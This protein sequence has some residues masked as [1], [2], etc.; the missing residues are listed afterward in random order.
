[1]IL[2]SIKN[3]KIRVKLLLLLFLPASLLIYLSYS[4][5]S[6]EQLIIDESEKLIQ[7]IELSQSLS[8]I[9]HEIQLERGYTGESFFGSD[10]G[11]E[12]L[13]ALYINT[14]ERINQFLQKINNSSLFSYTEFQDEIELNELIVSLDRI[15]SVRHRV[16]NEQD[17]AY[18]PYFE[19]YTKLI[20]E[21]IIF[22]KYLQVISSDSVILHKITTYLNLLQAQEYAGQERAILNTIF[23]KGEINVELYRQIVE[24]ISQQN[25]FLDSFYQDGF[26]SFSNDLVSR[27]NTS[28]TKEMLL[29]RQAG[30]DKAKKNSVLNQLQN[31]IGYGGLIHDFKNFVMRGNT[32][33]RM[34]FNQDIEKVKILINEYS[35]LAGM[36][37]KERQFLKVIQTTLEK[38][39]SMLMVV[40][41][42]KKQGASI[43][44]IDHIVNIND[45]PAKTA[46]G[47][48]STYVTGLESGNWFSVSTQR[49]ENMRQ[50][51][52]KLEDDI[53]NTVISKYKAESSS[54]LLHLILIV[55]VLAIL[56][57]LSFML[58]RRMVVEV[59]AMTKKIKSM[60][61]SGQF[62]QLLEV[63]GDDEIAL[64]AD[65]FDSLILK[66]REYQKKMWQQAY[67]DDL[68]GLANRKRCTE[69]IVEE[70][71]RS[72]RSHTPFSVLFI[73][74]D[75]FKIINDSLGHQIGDDLLCQA[76]KRLELTI[77]N[78]DLL[79][80][81]GGD[82]FVIVLT[83][84]HNIQ[85][86]KV[87]ANSL[88]NAL[89]QNFVLDGVHQTI[90]SGSIGIAMYPDDGESV[91]ILLKNADT[92][93]YQ[94]K[95]KGK[96][97]YQFFTQ[98]MNFRV[99]NYMKIEQDMHTALEYQQFELFY[100]PVIDLKSKKIVS[101]EAL[102]RWNSPQNGLVF[103]DDFVPI[104]EETGMIVPL[105]KWIM[106]QAMWQIKD[107]NSR[108]DNKIKMAINV[109][110]RQFCDRNMPIYK[111]LNDLLNVVG[112]SADLIE[113]EITENLLMENSSELEKTLQQISEKGFAIFM[114]D[115]GT[116]YSSLSYL[117]KFPIDVLKIDRSFVWNMDKD[118]GDKRLV[119]S[120]INMAKSMELTV[121][122]E[123]VE[124][125]KHEKLLA[126]MGCDLAQ[127][128]LYSK[129]VPAKELEEKFLLQSD[130]ANKGKVIPL[131]IKTKRIQ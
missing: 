99:M 20:H 32:E 59:S 60:R 112:I 126:E 71:E 128:Y 113:L 22:I 17:G 23:L 36:S 15:K 115:F 108:C 70:I 129:P 45:R 131:P 11:T 31:I 73:D 125:D 119:K 121:L 40:E 29:L 14:D 38:Y 102:I 50:V 109:S 42:M 93:M 95:D 13:L 30:L 104:A 9:V 5:I 91:E 6:T 106:Q 58:I 116:G 57:L 100:Q 85:N 25:S 54:L 74:L 75:R 39:H 46:I 127:G 114:D 21:I 37:K 44:E 110:S 86:V 84:I 81:I 80:R 77:R 24:I 3:L 130:K 8:S 61:S 87:V 55:F 67:Y 65:A 90:I 12:Q 41:N 103:P 10:N 7:F 97:Q 43:E 83:E 111:V 92:A 26:E 49:I 28:Q 96:D 33:Y 120:I 34:R 51:S 68:T 1:M 63:Q 123:G 88:L 2:S 52:L 117:K 78:T 69:K 19:N 122:A 62:D 66:Q 82:E 107:W 47:L 94:A 124:T 98:E 53:L 18:Q 118:E 72:A 27:L 101:V 76:A 48:L 89:S 4:Q 56:I 64:M 35:Q 79:S 16:A 105:G